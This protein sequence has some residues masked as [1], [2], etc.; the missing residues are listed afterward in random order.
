M[1]KLSLTLL[2]ALV[3]T[4]AAQAAPGAFDGLYLGAQ[5]G[6]TQRNHK[7]ATGKTNLSKETQEALNKKKKANGVNFG[8]YT[9]YGQNNNGFYW[10]G[11]LNIEQSSANNKEINHDHEVTIPA[12]LIAPERKVKKEAAY[13]YER[14]IVFG[15]APRLGA[16]IANDNLIYAKLGM[17]ISRD[18]IKYNTDSAYDKTK[19]N[20][21]FVPGVGYE[22]AFGKILARVEYGYNL[23]GKVKDENLTFKYSAHVI[24]AGLAYK[25]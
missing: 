13:T 9:G 2:G 17:E 11:E 5:L 23:G 19:T 3:L 15:L 18:T 7:I 6:Y 12:T 25:F 20:V 1:K 22:R 16:V 21:V 14:S 8:F 4:Q 24:K 10:G